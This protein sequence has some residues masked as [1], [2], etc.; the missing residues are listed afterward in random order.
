M[1]DYSKLAEA[2]S[3]VSS[4]PIVPGQP[5]ADSFSGLGNSPIMSDIYGLYHS[6]NPFAEATVGDVGRQA[7]YAAPGLGNAL[8]ARDS[9][10]SFRSGD[11]LGSAIA[12][13]GAIPFFGGM[14]K[15]FEVNYFGKNLKVLHNPSPMETAG[16][17][18]RTKYKAAR[19][20]VDPT[21]GDTFIWDAADP[22]LHSMMAETLGVPQ[23]EHTIADVIGLD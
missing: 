18:N 19:R 11:Y 16:F 21:N 14:A 10:D 9:A 5:V 3:G 23:T 13:L 1:T 8:S 6:L 15:P 7:A 4:S 17:L 20:L 2:L 22:A 12:G